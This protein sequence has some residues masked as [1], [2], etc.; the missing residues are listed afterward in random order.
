MM[1]K[2][3]KNDQVIIAIRD[4]M[5]R[6]KVVN[7]QKK[8]KELVER[9][10]NSGGENYQVG[11]R[12]MRLLAIKEGIA[13]VEVYS[14]E[15]EQQKTGITKCPVCES[16][17]KKSRNQ[18]VFGGTVTLAHTCPTCTYWTGMKRRVPVRY[19]FTIKRR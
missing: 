18:T 14:R 13:Q 19:V 6:Y 15:T 17:L 10:L 2:I 1:Y 9:E 5:A 8:L 16:K 4:V 11:E 12:R 3:P 7:S